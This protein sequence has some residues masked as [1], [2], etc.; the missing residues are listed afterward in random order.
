MRG[1]AAARPASKLERGGVS[2]W[3]KETALKAVGC[4]SLAGSNPVASA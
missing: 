1:L 3:P 2:E 4:N